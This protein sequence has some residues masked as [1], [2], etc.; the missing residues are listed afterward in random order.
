MEKKL[1][2]LVTG[3]SGFL[4][5]HI[6]D[7]L[8]DNGHKV[9][10]FDVKMSPF[11]R[12]DQ[13]MIVG[14]LLDMADLE[15]AVKN[16]EVVFH[17]AGMADIDECAKNPV[18]AAEHNVL[19]TV[20]LLEACIKHKV[21]RFMFASTAYV[22]SK[23]GYFYKS[24]KQACESFIENYADLYGLKYTNLRYGSLYGGRSNSS[25]SIYKFI[26]Q[27]IKESK[28]TY[29][30]TG[31]EIRE[32][33]HVNDAAEIT[34]ECLSQEFENC[35][36]MVTGVEK[37]RYKDLLVMIKEIFNDTID[38]EILPSKR[39]AHYNITPYNFTPSIGQ[40]ITKNKFIDMGEGILRIIQNVHYQYQQEK[41]NVK[42]GI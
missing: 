8:S 34:V 42:I 36:I 6:A 32:F 16:K 13:E 11:L 10:I 4:G 9:T 14:N 15:N 29:Y 22:Y 25:N 37:M 28:I 12:D 24:S 23:A 21:K 31:E 17:L 19:G 5:S 39:K 30:G 26:E 2:I 38:I 35:H 40:K 33:I 27:A 20:K 3:G 41:E 18:A 1:N 7:I